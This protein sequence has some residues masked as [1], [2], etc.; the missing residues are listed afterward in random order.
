M[1]EK[2][3]DHRTTI[4]NAQPLISPSVIRE[5]FRKVPR[6]A[7]HADVAVQG[8]MPW[9]ILVAFG[10]IWIT[11]INDRVIST[12]D[13]ADL[14]QGTLLDGSSSSS[15]SWPKGQ[16]DTCEQ[17]R[18]HGSASPASVAFCS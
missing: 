16:L 10:R 7:P 12:I 15:S 9:A 3:A 8:S 1:F 5:L 6:D 13:M 14:S 2:L 4:E 18:D 17:S 11:H